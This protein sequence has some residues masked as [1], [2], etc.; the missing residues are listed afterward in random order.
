MGM[1]TEFYFRADIVDGPVD[2]WFDVQINGKGWFEEP[3]SDPHE[4]FDT[5][6]WRH[7]FIGGGAVY[8]ESRSP[9]YRPR[10]RPGVTGGY[11]NQLVLSS[12]LKEYDDEIRLFVSWVEPYLEHLD[13]DYLGFSLYEDSRPHV[14]G[15]PGDPDRES[16]VLYFKGQESV[17]S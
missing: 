13:G 6:R 9:I 12:S 16:P 11:T 5:P 3:F 10:R 7:V 2:D 14:W 1:Y 15:R 4:F 17:Q 8:Q